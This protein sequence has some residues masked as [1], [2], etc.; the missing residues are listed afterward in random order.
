MAGSTAYER[1]A[2]EDRFNQPTARRLK[3]GLD[4]KA[5]K[6]FD[7][8]RG[9]LLEL[10]GVTEGYAWRGADLGAPRPRLLLYLWTCAG[11]TFSLAQVV[12]LVRFGARPFPLI[13]SWASELVWY[14]SVVAALTFALLLWVNAE[15]HHYPWEDVDE[16]GA[17]DDEPGEGYEG[18]PVDEAPR[19]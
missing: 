2:W 7:L 4:G 9:H 17:W 11:G 3:A 13:P 10:D 18:D 19:A 15:G 8:I 12:S 16:E 14:F 5:A 1:I 6:L